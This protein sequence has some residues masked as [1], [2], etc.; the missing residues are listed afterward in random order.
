M[1]GGEGGLGG[2]ETECE[3]GNHDHER[4]A[5]L[6]VGK[7]TRVRARASVSWTWVRRISEVTR[8]FIIQDVIKDVRCVPVKIA[9]AARALGISYRIN[10]INRAA[11]MHIRSG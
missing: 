11:T 7:Q 9:I 6:R 4:E 1:I 3:E 10:R 2:A 8:A 5:H